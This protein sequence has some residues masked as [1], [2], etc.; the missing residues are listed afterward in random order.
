MCRGRGGATVLLVVVAGVAIPG[1][2]TSTIT[3]VLA[4]QVTTVPS[5]HFFFPHLK[6]GPSVSCLANSGLRREN[7]FVNVV[8]HERRLWFVER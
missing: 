4:V 7:I 3:L 6:H 2:I 8:G 5:T 1:S